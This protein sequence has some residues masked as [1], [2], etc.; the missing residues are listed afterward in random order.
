MASQSVE[1]LSR[2]LEKSRLQLSTSLQ[3]MRRSLDFSR[4]IKKS[5]A[6]HTV[7]YLAGGVLT[8]AILV[9]LIV[10]KPSKPEV[11]VPARFTFGGT[12]EKEKT[13]RSAIWVAAL[14]FAAQLVKPAIVD[15]LKEQARQRF[16]QR[17]AASGGAAR[18]GSRL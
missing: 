10:R 2:E 5:Y 16:M 6:E 8:G 18:P 15:F 3:G 14:G 1:D 13:K 11:E 4:R 7:S 12:K 9:Y 17:R